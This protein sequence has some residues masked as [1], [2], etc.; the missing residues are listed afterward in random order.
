MEGSR[1]MIYHEVP[2]HGGDLESVSDLSARER[3]D[4][5]LARGEAD[6]VALLEVCPLEV[7]GPQERIDE[8]DLE[9]KGEDVW[10]PEPAPEPAPFVPCGSLYF[11]QGQALGFCSKPKGHD[12]DPGDPHADPHA[13]GPLV[14]G[15]K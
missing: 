4:E 6:L 2:G 7:H 10:E 5:L 1:L 11:E 15:G 3:I 8:L 9:R 13:D 12:E 14:W